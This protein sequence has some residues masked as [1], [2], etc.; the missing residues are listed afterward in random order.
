MDD[1]DAVF[2]GSTRNTIKFI[3]VVLLLCC[4]Y[5]GALYLLTLPQMIQPI[6]IFIFF[7]LWMLDMK[8]SGEKK[9]ITEIISALLSLGQAFG[10]IYATFALAEWWMVYMI[11]IGIIAI[12][13]IFLDGSS[14]SVKIQ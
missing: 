14:I 9:I 6:F 12:L 11:S 10:C 7:V 4:Y 13:E 8:C 3:L 5:Y 1:L 2:H